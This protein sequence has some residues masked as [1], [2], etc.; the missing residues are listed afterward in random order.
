MPPN[1]NQNAS[2]LPSPNANKGAGSAPSSA[3][4]AQLG[5]AIA[6]ATSMATAGINNLSSAMSGLAK[7]SAGAA[8]ALAL[9]MVA[10]ESGIAAVNVG[11]ARFVKLANPGVFQRFQL[12]IDDL[13]ASIG[14]ALTP[15]LVK[16][17]DVFRSIGSVIFSLSG[18][19][20]KVI[21]AVAAATVGLVTFGAVTITLATI[22]GT[23][24]AAMVAFGSA[25][26]VVIAVFT[27]GIGPIV[28]A[29]GGL[30]A[31]ALA[32]LIPVVTGVAS[33]IGAFALVSGN[34]NGFINKVSDAFSGLMT[35]LGEALEEFT[36]A[37]VIGP[38]LK[39]LGDILKDMGAVFGAVIK[40]IAPG[41]AAMISAWAPLIPV[42]LKVVAAITALLF[43]TSPLGALFTGIAAAMFLIIKAY[44]L[45]RPGLE[46]IANLIKTVFNEVISIFIDLGES[47]LQSLG[48]GNALGNFT[49]AM[50]DVGI[51]IAGVARAITTAMQ[52]VFN[53]IRGF[54]GLTLPGAPN[55]DDDKRRP[56]TN[57]GAAA[58][59]VSTGSVDDVLR[60]A[61]ESAFSLGSG[62][63]D[64]AAN[65]AANTAAINLAIQQQSAVIGTIATAVGNIITNITNLPATAKAVINQELTAAANLVI[66]H[67]PGQ[68]SRDTARAVVNDISGKGLSG[69]DYKQGLQ[70]T[71]RDQVNAI[72][73]IFQ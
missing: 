29:I 30:L 31:G 4:W 57:Y 35:V 52:S 2:N 51:M 66:A 54:L 46:E 20:Q 58:K 61:R 24:A 22:L 13:Y 69:S 41:I 21:Q 19:G 40:A 63:N 44:E 62:A 1:F 71:I 60:K 16:L 26:E 64:P 33:A 39:A 34:L 68:E 49:K 43:V 6:D 12:A 9:P 36:K 15:V 72:R 27:G 38:V 37:D 50:Q 3:G 11:I 59:S 14:R 48:F 53:W 5:K 55:A 23:G 70:D 45:L 56:D 18:P 25:A 17:T 32:S 7:E 47:I 28:T 10:L 67:I 42:I 65:T 8:A 73:G